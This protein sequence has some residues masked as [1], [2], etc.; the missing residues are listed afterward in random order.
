MLGPYT[1]IEPESGH[2]VT[3]APLLLADF[4]LPLGEGETV[5]D[6]GTGAGV[7]PLILAS[8]TPVKRIVGVEVQRAL[9]ETARKNVELNSLGGRVELIEGD[10]RDLPERFPESS[11]SLVLSNP[12]FVKRDGGRRSPDV[13]RDVAR[14]EVF[15]TLGDLLQTSAY[16]AG[17]GGRVAYI[18]PVIRLKEML[19]GLTGVGLTPTRLRFIHAT[20]EKGADLFLVEASRSGTLQVEAPLITHR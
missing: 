8:K 6:I 17:S 10:Y 18:F 3:D 1:Y 13:S 11:F 16:L 9:V 14:S 7:I 20:P 19:S 15:G 4:I 12:P 5:I 2:K